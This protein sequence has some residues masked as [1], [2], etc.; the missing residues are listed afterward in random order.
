MTSSEATRPIFP[1]I[2]LAACQRGK[3]SYIIS[4]LTATYRIVDRI[5]KQNVNLGPSLMQS[6]ELLR[7]FRYSICTCFMLNVFLFPLPTASIDIAKFLCCHNGI[8]GVRHDS[9]V[10]VIQ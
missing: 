3:I 8:V 2:P 5:S 9:I 7:L 10:S 6:G 1:K 4:L